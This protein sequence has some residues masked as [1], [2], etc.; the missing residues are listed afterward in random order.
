[1]GYVGAPNQPHLNIVGNVTY[2]PASQVSGIQYYNPANGAT[3]SESRNYNSL[4]QLTEITVSGIMDMVYTYP[5]AGANNGRI[6]KQKDNV[7]GEEINYQ[8]DALNRLITAYTT[9]STGG[10]SFSYDGFGNRLNQTVTKG[11]ALP[12]YLSVDMMSN[13]INSTGYSYD[14]NGNRMP[15]KPSQSSQV[16]VSSGWITTSPIPMSDEIARRSAHPF[17]LRRDSGRRRTAQRSDP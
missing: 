7:T 5:A 4:Y 2:N 3:V 10:L 17:E 14:A 16:A 6:A 13:R 8:Y 15:A 1:V 11:T 9:D 12:L